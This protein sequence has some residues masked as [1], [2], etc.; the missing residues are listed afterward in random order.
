MVT[1]SSLLITIFLTLVALAIRYNYLKN[2]RQYE[3]DELKSTT[4][5][6]YHRY[7]QTL[8]AHP[9]DPQQ[10]EAILEDEDNTLIIAG[11]GCG[12]TTTIQGKVSYLLDHGLASPE[13]ILLLS[14]AK[15]SADDLTAKMGH[16]GVNSR[17]FHSLAYQILKNSDQNPT[18]LSPNESEQLLVDI[19][20]R[21]SRDETYLSSFNDFVLNGLHPIKNENEFDSYADYIDYLKDSEFE[22]L[23]GLLGKRKYFVSDKDSSLRGEFVKNGEECYIAN[24]LFLHG[25][26]YTYD[27]PYSYLQ[28]IAE[29][30]P[31]DKHKSR[32][33]PTFTIY[34]NGVDDARNIVYLDHLPISAAGHSP[35][36]F[37]GNGQLSPTAYYAHL[38]QWKEDIHR[39]HRTQYI[40]S[41]SYEFKNN[42]IEENLIDNLLKHGIRP[43][44]RPNAEVYKMLEEVYGKEIDTVMKLIQTFINLFKSSD[45]SLEELFEAN[46]KLF[47]GDAELVDRNDQLLTIIKKLYTAYQEE[48]QKQRKL[49]FNDLINLAQEHIGQGK[50]RHPYKYIIVDEFQDISINRCKL[51]AS[52]KEQQHTKLFAVGDDWQ[53]IYRFSGS[54][55]TLFHKFQ[56]FFGHSSIKKIETTYRFADPMISISS[57]FLLKNPTQIKKTLRSLPNRRTDVLL[58]YNKADATSINESLLAI[59]Q[60]L[61]ITYGDDL[62][63]KSIL[64]LGRY[65]HDINRLVKGNGITVAKKESYIQLDTVVRNIQMDK[66]GNTSQNSQLR[67]TKKINFYTVH[68]S[69]G[70]EADI[71]ILIN[72]ENGKYGFPSELSDDKLLN[73]L[74]SG[75]DQYPNSEE[76]R[77]FYVALTRAK[78]KFYFL[79]SRNKQSKF[80]RELYTDFVGT[81]KT[82][83]S[84]KRCGGELRFVKTVFGKMGTSKMYGCAN[85]KYGCDYSSFVKQAD[86]IH[87]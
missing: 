18:V 10:V 5:A 53:S 8:L 9:L 84:C 14:F 58:E 69:K 59:L 22:S 70:L 72:C 57:Q 56:D 52:L 15:K 47:K 24:F 82:A 51:L 13:E 79:A 75:D 29:S 4:K 63:S 2:K 54:D 35:K 62:Q 61:Y 68:K 39:A 46:K 44:R 34:R 43:K 36:F 86:A 11:A 85:Y 78:E 73:L 37:K 1:F 40:K 27:A 67:L 25:I 83:R 71:V 23:Q 80:V 65:Q 28:N 66:A 50:H 32:Y 74:L 6:K 16:L 7:F 30:A 20:H 42:T 64:L 45:K 21:M 76:R 31:Y 26:P 17:T 33:K 19:H 49:D 55:L 60:K 77:L 38:L 12:K 48:L 81:P 41:Y 87:S 3:K